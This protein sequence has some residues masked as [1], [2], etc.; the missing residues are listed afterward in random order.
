MLDGSF[1]TFV[2]LLVKCFRLIFLKSFFINFN[3]FSVF[4]SHTKC[5]FESLSRGNI[6][7]SLEG[8]VTTLLSIVL[9]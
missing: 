4:H 8:L 6:T 2:V 1:F 9:F 5:V 7:H 3:Y